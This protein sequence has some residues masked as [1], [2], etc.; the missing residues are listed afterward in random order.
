M[1]LQHRPQLL[2]QITEVQTRKSRIFPSFCIVKH[3]EIALEGR[4][5]VPR[6]D[7]PL[8]PQDRVSNIEENASKSPNH[9][10]DMIRGN[11]SKKNTRIERSFKSVK[12]QVVDRENEGNNAEMNDF[13][14]PKKLFFLTVYIMCSS[15]I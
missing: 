12:V 9:R 2:L 4:P 6:P 13:F 7:R 15:S 1:A 14:E 11:S 3:L 8:R 10:H 5:A